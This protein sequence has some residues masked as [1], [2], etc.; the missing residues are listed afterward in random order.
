M[1]KETFIKVYLAPLMWALNPDI[2]EIRFTERPNSRHQI[3]AIKYKGGVT[4]EHVDVTN[5]SLE[6]FTLEIVADILKYLEN[7]RRYPPLGQA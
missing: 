1:D 6:M 2:E 7:K 5:K 4:F 3:I